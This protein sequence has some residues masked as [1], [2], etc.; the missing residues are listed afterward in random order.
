MLV[1]GLMSGTSADGIDA[2]LCDLTGAPPSLQA[3]MVHTIFV[4]FEEDFQQR[5]YH[6]GHP[7]T[8]HIDDIC[9]LSFDLGERFSAAVLKLIAE[10]QLKP[11]DVDLIGLHG[12]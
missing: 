11:Q 10:A 4:P 8:S 1:I 12:Q 3:R 5:I 2:A 9:E 7:Q 6:A